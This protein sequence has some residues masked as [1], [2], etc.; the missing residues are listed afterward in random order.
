[1]ES[2][3]EV[4]DIGLGRR[5]L[6]RL[7]RVPKGSPDEMT[8]VES[9]LLAWAEESANYPDFYPKILDFGRTSFRGG[10]AIFLVCDWLNG[11]RLGERVRERG[12][13]APHAAMVVVMDILQLLDQRWQTDQRPH[14]GLNPLTVLLTRADD[15]HKIQLDAWGLLETIRPHWPELAQQS[16]VES[17][18]LAPEQRQATDWGPRTDIWAVG[19]LLSY[20]LTGV[21]P[22]PFG[23]I[24]IQGPVQTIIDTFTAD[25]PAARPASYAAALAM[26]RVLLPK[27]SGPHMVVA[28]PRQALRV[29]PIL[30]LTLVVGLLVGSAAN[31]AASVL[32]NRPRST[33]SQANVAAPRDASAR[34]TLTFV[35]VEC[36]PAGA[37]IRDSGT[38]LGVCPLPIAFDGAGASTRH[39]EISAPGY[40]TATLTVSPGDGPHKVELQSS[41]DKSAEGAATPDQPHGDAN[42]PS[43]VWPAE[44]RRHSDLEPRDILSGNAG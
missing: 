23:S 40:E 7:L 1:M 35:S 19:Q 14:L 36:E 21:E 29:T 12:P 26:L 13:V 41:G 39:L 17:M 16:S 31:F 8:T 37:T 42:L 25:E 22:S 27:I 2:S 38:L 32:L 44:L 4:Y 6:L 3:V 9:A 33:S 28:T 24:P 20:L 30:G 34:S 43:P 15:G 18:W 5:A 11:Q 10:S